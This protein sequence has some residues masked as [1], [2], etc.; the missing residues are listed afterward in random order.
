MVVLE[1]FKGL[2][3][4]REFID[5]FRQKNKMSNMIYVALFFFI[6]V[7]VLLIPL[8]LFMDLCIFGYKIIDNMNTKKQFI[9]MKVKPKKRS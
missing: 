6:I 2:L 1:S 9:K 3:E 7:Y 5:M 4:L 8:M